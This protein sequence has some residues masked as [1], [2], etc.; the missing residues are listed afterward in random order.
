MSFSDIN[1]DGAYLGEQMKNNYLTANGYSTWRM[2]Q[3]GTSG[4]CTL[5][6]IFTSEENL[7]GGSVVPNR[8]AGN[9]F[10]IVGWWGHGNS[11]GA[12]VGYGSCSDGAFMLSSNAPGL[13]DTHPSFTYQCSCLNGYP[14]DAGNLQYAILKK[15]GIATVGATRVSWYSPG[16]TG[17]AMSVTNAG[18]GYE[19]MKRLVSEKPAADALHLM[20]SSMYPY[21]S[22]WLMNY[23]AFNVY[24]D[25]S[26]SIKN[27]SVPSTWTSLG[28]YLVTKHCAIIDDQGRRHV[29]AIGGNNE[30]WD[31][32]D[33]TW[34]SLG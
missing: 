19:Y 8:W 30:L 29:F 21:V 13:D 9:D 27:P 25:P 33:G 28:G 24:G 11:Q 20:K 18:M 34:I 16:Q 10:G 1:T 3:Q 17:F 12:Y 2:Y 5:D 22:A 14:E 7:R 31:N 32:V 26:I 6:S 23:Y 15:G 4:S